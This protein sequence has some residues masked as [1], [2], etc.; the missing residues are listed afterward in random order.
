MREIVRVAR[1][2]ITVAGP[3]ATLDAGAVAVRTVP[4]AGV[5]AIPVAA[6]CILPCFGGRLLSF[7]AELGTL[8]PFGAHLRIDT[9]LCRA[10]GAIRALAPFAA[11]PLPAFAA[12]LL[13]GALVP[14]AAS[15]APA[16]RYTAGVRMS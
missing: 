2:P 7:A 11:A 5:S 9:D 15:A 3:V 6:W 14:P 13:L 10:F 12:V 8:R 16:P 4:A 1:L